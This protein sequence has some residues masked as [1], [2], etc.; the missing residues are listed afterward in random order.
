M[1]IIIPAIPVGVL[2]LLNFFA[3]Y[4]IALVNHPGWKAG[5]KRLVAIVVSVLI[6]LVVL[7]LYYLMTGDAVPA[8]WV[9]L[10]VGVLVCQAAY[11]LLYPS[12]SAVEARHGIK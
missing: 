9:L 7:V 5:S 10:L 12:A 8:W 6:T 11:T 3:P 4:L 2:T 1:D